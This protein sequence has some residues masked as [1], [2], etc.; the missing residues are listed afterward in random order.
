M[1]QYD[2]AKAIGCTVQSVSNWESGRNQPSLRLLQQMY[3]ALG[4]RASFERSGG[5]S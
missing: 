3:D 1:S 5:G 4:V 2:L